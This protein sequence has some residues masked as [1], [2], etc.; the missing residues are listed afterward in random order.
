MYN[1]RDFKTVKNIVLKNVPE[2]SKVILFGSYAKGDARE[3]SDMDIIILTDKVY[4]REEKLRILTDIRWETADAGYRA[5]YII[6]SENDF[7]KERK[8]P[9]MSKTIAR[10]GKMLWTKA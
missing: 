5:D 9:T 2:A 4:D 1:K 7:I 10:E 6:K 3:E 8:L